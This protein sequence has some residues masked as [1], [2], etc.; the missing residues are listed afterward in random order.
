MGFQKQG[1]ESRE[2]WH[3]F[4]EEQG[5]GW[6]DPMKHDVVTLQQFLQTYDTASGDLPSLDG[7][8]M[9]VQRIK[10]YQRAGLAERENWEEFAGPM[11]DPARHDVSILES[12][13]E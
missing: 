10:H 6:R 2:I 1:E 8:P 3:S 11:K 5:G 9:L 13:I 7:K 12:F 4:C